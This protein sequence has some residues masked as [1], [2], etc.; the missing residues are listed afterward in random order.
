[1]AGAGA[2]E[3]ADAVSAE[4]RAAIIYNPTK[5]GIQALKAAVAEAESE[6]GWGTSEWIETAEDDPGRGMAQTAL[7]GGFELVIAAGGDGTVRSVAAGLRSSGVPFALVPLGT[8]NLLARNLG[9]PVNDVTDALAIAFTGV[10][11]SVDV[12]V[13]QVTRPDGSVEEDVSLV[14]AGLGIDAAMIAMTR[15]E[16]KKRVGWLA[17]VDAGLRALPA[18][19]PFRIH[20]RLADGRVHRARV[21]TILVANLGVLPGNIE[22]IPDA[23]IDDGKLDVAVLQP[24]NALGW[25]FIWRRVAWENRVLRK[26]A[27]GRQVIDLTGANKRREII[28]LRGR[29]VSI[30]IDGEAE[31][32]ELDGDAFGKATAVDFSIDP[33]GLTIRV[34][35]END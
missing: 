13:V 19:I 14:M 29:S 1:V 30:R 18:S 21:S 5:N 27:I 15:P 6:H 11:R 23:E 34:A 32:L 22:L 28:Y 8:G 35:P 33:A 2:V 16:L 4:R 9:I 25:L 10:G 17:Y 26:T 7:E 3:D 20:Y 12:T 31:E 24:K